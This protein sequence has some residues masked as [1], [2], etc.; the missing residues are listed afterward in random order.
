MATLTDSKD[1]HQSV[2]TIVRRDVATL[3]ENL[4]IQQALDT[5]RAHGLGERIIYFYVL[6]SDDRLVG[7][8]PTRRL[9]TAPLNQ[10]LSDLM[11]RR[12]VTIQETATILETHD[13]LARHKLLALPAIDQDGRISG[14]ID[15][16]M[17]AAEAFE[18]TERARVDEIFEAIGF[19]VTQVRSAS[20]FGAFRFRF[21]WL[22][23][24]IASGTLC[25]LLVS[26]FDITLAKSVVLAFLLTLVLGLGESVSI[27]SMTVTI[28]S[29]RPMRPTLQWYA[30]ALRRELGTALLLGTASGAIVGA[31]VWLWFG[32]GLTAIAIGGSLIGVIGAS[33]LFGISVPTL[34]HALRLDLKIAAGPMTLAIADISTILIYFGTAA[35]LI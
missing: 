7:V 11:I 1:Y 18:I 29:L 17:F 16:G 32:A 19:R 8:V 31:T 22:M 26:S 13:A 3:H 6:N 30:G 15:V 34:L 4:T 35:L 33:C 27:Q 21:P 24:T 10:K 25:A 23:A 9:L 12:I 28:Q 14:V 2:L 20:P 5:I